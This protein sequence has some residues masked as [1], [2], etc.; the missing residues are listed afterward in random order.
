MTRVSRICSNRVVSG[1]AR[2]RPAEDRIDPGNVQ[3]VPGVENHRIE[4]GPAGH[5]AWSPA[6][7]LKAQGVPIEIADLDSLMDQV[8][9]MGPGIRVVGHSL[10]VGLGG[11][12]GEAQGRAGSEGGEGN[13]WKGVRIGSQGAGSGEL[14]GRTKAARSPC[15]YR[16][17]TALKLRAASAGQSARRSGGGAG[18]GPLVERLA[19]KLG[20]IA[21]VG[22]PAIAG[23]PEMQ[24][25]HQEIAHLFATTAAAAIEEQRA[26]PSIS[27]WWG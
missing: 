20:G 22:I 9:I 1:V 6:C 25:A 19:V 16:P 18:S 26:S 15:I 2:A 24:A 27:A 13:E 23:M 4:P 7:P 3:Q 14:T 11:R 21:D 5:Q 10:G 17:I 8:V 12:S